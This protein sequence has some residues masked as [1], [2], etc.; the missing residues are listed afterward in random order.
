MYEKMESGYNTT[1][2][3]VTRGYVKPRKVALYQLFPCIEA[4]FVIG[5]LRLRSDQYSKKGKYFQ[6]LATNGLIEARS[7]ICS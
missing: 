3:R 5:A 6:C 2:E 7:F 4:V 1:S